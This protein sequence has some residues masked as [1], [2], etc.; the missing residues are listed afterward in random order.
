MPVNS[1]GVP[2]AFEVATESQAIGS[3]MSVEW[4]IVPRLRRR[5]FADHS[6]I[7][8]QISSNALRCLSLPREIRM[9]RI[10]KENTMITG[11]DKVLR[12]VVV[13]ASMRKL[14][15]QILRRKAPCFS[16]G[17]TPHV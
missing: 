7:S 15:Y 16:N 2:S 13:V 3:F 8:L 10:I 14:L 5:S 6:S 17:D 1:T 4:D 11:A 12:R 9:P